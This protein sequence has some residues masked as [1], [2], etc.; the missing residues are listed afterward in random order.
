MNPSSLSATAL[1]T[2][3]LC[4]ARF[5]AEHID[6]SKG[7]G[8]VAA[9]IGTAVHGGLE[10][11]VK[12]VYLDKSHEPSK[13]LLEDLYK[14]SYMTT[15]GTADT[16]RDEYEDGLDL[17]RTWFGRTDLTG[18][19]VMSCEIKET[20]MVPSP[21][22]KTVKFPFNY[23]W[24]RFDYLGNNEYR[25]VDYK[26]S[27]WNISPGDL[28]AKIQARCY[29]LAAQIKFPQAERIWVQFD[30]LRYD[31]VGLV[32]TKQ[33]N[34]DTWY[35]IKDTLKK[36]L[37]APDD[38]DETL[39]PEC[40][41]CVRKLNCK[42]LERNVAVGGAFGIASA[43]EAI[44]KRAV[45]QYQLDA[46]TSAIGDLDDIIIREAKARDILEFESDVNSIEITASR[47]R[48]IDAER[49]LEA[50]GGA[51]F[52]KYGGYKVSISQVDKLLKDKSVSEEIKNTVKQMVYMKT[53]EPKV[54]VKPK[55]G[56]I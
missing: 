21:Y 11:Y 2:A 37:D 27:R 14:M 34:A 5:K 46:I 42:A 28:N 24:D 38:P 52:A 25:V 15:F 43:A 1:N 29:A 10:T 4:L 39:N 36:I 18:V 7:V 33:Q 20:F 16:S 55:R 32:F 19:E 41:F 45:L 8:G 53:G 44:D 40:R 17:T 22:D 56:L 23:I 54:K 35:F 30:M 13:S 48:A 26:T 9:S 50:V 12:A 6:R 49:F 3:E 51:L 47:Q 31:S